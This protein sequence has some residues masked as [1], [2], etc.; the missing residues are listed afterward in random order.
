MNEGY[1]DDIRVATS[2]AIASAATTDELLHQIAQI[3]TEHG[4]SDW[5]SEDATFIAIGEGMREAGLAEAD[6]R[7]RA[8]MIAG[9][10]AA[11]EEKI[12]TGFRV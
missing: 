8:S 4:V 2:T 10:N 9:G 11:A 7:K 5:E 1:Q 3:A 6:V 12:L